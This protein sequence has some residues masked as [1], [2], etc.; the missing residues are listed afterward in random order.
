MTASFGVELPLQALF[1]SPTL[2]G[3]SLEVGEAVLTG[4]LD[5]EAMEEEILEEEV[6]YREARI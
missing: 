1:R 5:E 6:A 2:G 4:A 3:F